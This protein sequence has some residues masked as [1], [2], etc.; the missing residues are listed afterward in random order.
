MESLTYSS[1]LKLIDSTVAPED[2]LEDY[3]L[4]GDFY[5]AAGSNE[6]PGFDF[7]FLIAYRN[8]IREAVVPYFVTEFKFNTMF[9]EGWLKQ[10]MGN[11]GIRIACVGHPC[12][13]FGRIEGKLS[14]ELLAQVYSALKMRASVVALKGFGQDLSAHGFVRVL[15]LPVAVLQLRENF[16]ATLKSHKRNFQRKIK[17][18]SE[19]R[20]ELIEG[21]PTQYVE[22]VYQLYLNTHAKANVRFECL[23]PTYFSSTAHLSSYLLAFSGEKMVGFLQIVRKGSRTNSFYIGLDYAVDRRLGVYFALQ[24]RAVD[25]AISRSCREIELGETSYTFKKNMGCDLIDTW[26]YYRHR[27]WFANL[28]LARLAFLL[29]PSDKELL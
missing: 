23:S 14:D 15:G 17:A 20:F 11:F 2:F 26:I 1:S 25:I 16:W 24:L 22:Q 29:A 6:I 19:L 21:L 8:G 4:G 12:V 18:A 5:R 7:R 3:P 28:I 27:N 9:D 13:S 10:T